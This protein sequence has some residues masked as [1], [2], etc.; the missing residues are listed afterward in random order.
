MN[1][2]ANMETEKIIAAESA[3]LCDLLVPAINNHGGYG[4]WAF[5]E[6]TDP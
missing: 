5:V 2:L 4:R 1:E 3:N 6:I